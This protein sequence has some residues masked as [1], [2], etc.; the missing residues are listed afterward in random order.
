MP[1]SNKTIAKNTAFLYARMLL[2][3]AVTFYTSRVILESL[4]AEDYG[5]YNVVGGIVAIMSFL[6]GALSASTSRFLT[7]EL[8]K[9]D[10]DKLKKTF[11]ASLILHILAAL[12]VLLLGETVGLWFF[13]EKLVIPDARMSAAFWVYQFSIIT[14]MIA[15]TQV[16]YNATLIAHENMSIYAFVGLYEALS[17]LAIVY[18]IYVS[19]IDKLVFY[20]LLWMLNACAIQLFYR[21]YTTKKYSECH[22]RIVKDKALYK[23]LLKYSGWDMFGG[24]AVVCQ[25]QGINILLNIFFGPIVNTARAIAVQVQGGVQIFVQNFL[26]AVRPQVVKSYAEGNPKR[27]IDL[28]FSAAKFAYLLMLALVLPVCFE[29]DFIL[30]IWLGGNAPQET[31]MFVIIILITYL[32]ET[33][34]IASLMPYHAIGKI[35]LGNIVGGSLMM[36][37]LPISYFVLKMGAPAYSVFIVIFVV[38]LLQMFW[39]WYIVHRYEKYSYLELIKK[40]YVPTVLITF[41]GVLAPLAISRYMESGWIRLIILTF[42]T[43]IIILISTYLIALDSKERKKLK[44]YIVLRIHRNE[45]NFK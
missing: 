7:F 9:G 38:N 14:T 11:S 40:V 5:I 2:V 37:A 18:L 12:L 13:Y 32:M 39:G 21:F 23:T 25:G 28:T 4:G 20:A 35:K 19:P 44:E 45:T 10:Q 34:H 3:M 31:R 26:M 42:T 6:N 17:R 30:K 33:F 29:A 15:F 16:P 36:M 8:G 22:F 43:I 1:T 24:L 41:I 27:M